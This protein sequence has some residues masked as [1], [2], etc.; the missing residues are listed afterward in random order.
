MLIAQHEPFFPECQKK[1]REKIEFLAKSSYY[2]ALTK[3]TSY[4]LYTHTHT[5]SLSLIHSIRR[6]RYFI[7]YFVR[8]A[9]LNGALTIL[10]C[11]HDIQCTYGQEKC[12]KLT[13]IT[14]NS[15]RQDSR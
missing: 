3:R 4:E 15:T 14:V 7:L 10:L 1:Q 2:Q 6:G 13:T 8:V 9:L 11:T 5:P 12:L